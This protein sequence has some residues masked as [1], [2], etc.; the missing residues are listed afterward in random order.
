MKTVLKLK[1]AQREILTNAVQ[2]FEKHGVRKPITVCPA[3]WR[4]RLDEFNPSYALYCKRMNELID[5]G[6][7]AIED[8]SI[9]Y[10]VDI[11]A[12]KKLLAA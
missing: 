12:T 11:D 7:I 8:L 9:A 3:H 10:I 6:F 2:S 4:D 1:K 5:A